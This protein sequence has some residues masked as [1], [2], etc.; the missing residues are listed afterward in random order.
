MA[1]KAFWQV[2]RLT[3]SSYLK[4]GACFSK[5]AVMAAAT[6]AWM[7][8][9]APLTSLSRRR[10]DFKAS[11]TTHV[12]EFP[13]ILAILEPCI[14]APRLLQD[15]AKYLD[16]CDLAFELLHYIDFSHIFALYC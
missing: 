3:C 4:L 9:V 11:C 10:M 14:A 2:R 13:I 6:S 16:L 12:P 8:S 5:A 15:L 1:F 7:L